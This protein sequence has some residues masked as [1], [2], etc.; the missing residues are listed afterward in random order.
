MADS[1]HSGSKIINGGQQQFF[2]RNS[3]LNEWSGAVWNN[4]F[5]GVQIQAD[6]VTAAFPDPPV[7]VFTQN[8]LSR[9]KPFLF[10]ENGEYFIH[11]PALTANS[12]GV[13]WTSGLSADA[14][15][16]ALSDFYVA[17]PKGS[18]SAINSRLLLGKHLLLLPGVYE[19][20]ESIVVRRPNTVVLGLG[21]ATLKAIEGAIPLVI[22]DNPG[23]IISGVTVDAGEV[24]SPILMQV[25]E[26][27][28]ILPGDPTNPITL[29]DIYFRVGGPYVGKADIALEVNSN[30]VLIDHA[31]VWR[32]DHG[33]EPFDKN[34][35]F[36]GDNQRWQQVIGRTGVVVNGDDVTATGL[37]VEHFQ[38]DNLVWNG[39]RGR[40]YFF[41][42]ELPYD[43]RNQADWPTDRVGYRV[44]DSVDNHEVWG[45]GVY[46][47]NRND[48]SIVTT[49]GFK[50]PSG[51]PG[52]KA[53][54][55]YTRNLSGPGTIQ[56]VING[57]G[58]AVQSDNEGPEYIVSYVGA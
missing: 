43:A 11:V 35:G 6:P 32:A 9:E 8:P 29:H 53:E 57:E 34:D 44:N 17:S 40:V 18:I 58:T 46:C 14:T 24:E 22:Q 4:V 27:G 51:K 56:Y 15:T 28:S 36:A 41:Q 7:T 10:S 13:S 20:A 30:H 2:A 31:W 54:R 37:F 52:V 23:I 48:P 42:N 21:L 12:E 38:E 3:A 39:E 16:L 5:M 47:Y 19:V 33:I 50:L 55:I 26:P 25:G 1:K 49:N 45:G